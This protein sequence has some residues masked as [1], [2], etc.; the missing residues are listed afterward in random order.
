MVGAVVVFAFCA[1]DGNG[2][3]LLVRRST[4]CHICFNFHDAEALKAV[5]KRLER[6]LSAY[7]CEFYDLFIVL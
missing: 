3:M 4:F 7:C 6:M 1:A 2:R 5:L